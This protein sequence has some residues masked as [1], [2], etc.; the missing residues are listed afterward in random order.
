MA[1]AFIAAYRK[2]KI[3]HILQN[4]HEKEEKSIACPFCS[5]HIKIHEEADIGST[6]NCPVCH[7]YVRLEDDDGRYM[8]VLLSQTEID[9]L[10]EQV[11]E[12][13]N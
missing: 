11:Q 1:D 10:Q 13:A 2:D 3:N 4:Y 5:T 12:S 7:R 9:E 6:H 8:G